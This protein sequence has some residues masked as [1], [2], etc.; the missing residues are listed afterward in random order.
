SA[1][2]VERAELVKAL[3]AGVLGTAPG[4]VTYNAGQ[5]F[6]G[7]GYSEDDILSKYYRDAAAWRFLGPGNVEVVRRHGD[8]LLRGW[9]E[10]GGRLAALP[11]EAALFEQVAQRKAL[12]VE[13]DE[14]RVLRS[15]LRALVNDWQAAAQR[16]ATNAL[17]AAEFAERLAGQ[18]ALLLASKALL[19]RT[20]ARLEQ[21]LGAEVES[22]LLRVWLDGTS[23]ALEEVEG[24]ARA[25]RAPPRAGEPRPVV[26][27]AAGPPVTRYA[28]YLAGPCPYDSGD[29]L[30]QT[31]DLAR[32]RLV[33]ELVETDPD[34]AACDREFRERMTEHFGRPRA[35]N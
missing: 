13:L 1:V 31:V 35:D 23:L 7:T 28:D 5:V 14:V 10:D 4:S 29:F 32:P 9:R 20:H 2:S 17:A 26:D 8:H 22:A 16:G 15:R 19:L 12:Q 18:D 25:L 30:T 6:G 3:A 27:P 21:G 34:L 33:P 11:D 24:V